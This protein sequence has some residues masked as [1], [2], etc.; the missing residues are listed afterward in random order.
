MINLPNRL[1]SSQCYL[2]SWVTGNAVPFLA[3][4]DPYLLTF[5]MG[6]DEPCLPPLIIRGIDDM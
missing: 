2:L 5:A 3:G 6:S 4:N 1:L